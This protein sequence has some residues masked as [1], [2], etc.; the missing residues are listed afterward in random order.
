MKTYTPQT[1]RS[2]TWWPLSE[3]K[4]SRRLALDVII[5]TLNQDVSDRPNPKQILMRED[6]EE[7]KAEGIWSHG[8]PFPAG[9]TRRASK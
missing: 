1:Q 4:Q 5:A 3:P 7:P 2:G 9:V 8:I 6:G